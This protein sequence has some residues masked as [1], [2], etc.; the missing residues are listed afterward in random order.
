MKLILMRNILVCAFGK[1]REVFV[2]V[3]RA[4][5]FTHWH[6]PCPMKSELA[7]DLLSLTQ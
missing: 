5:V 7:G 4:P 1:Y 3:L 2:E 6:S